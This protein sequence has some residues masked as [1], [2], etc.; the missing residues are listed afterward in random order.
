MNPAIDIIW[1]KRDLR[2]RDHLPLYNVMNNPR[3]VLLLYVFEPAVIADP[4]Y[5]ERHWRFVYQSLMDLQAQLQPFNTQVLIWHTDIFTA[6]EQISQDYQI[7]NLLSHEEIGLDVTYQRDKTLRSYLQQ[8]GI[9]WSEFPYSVVRRGLH[10]RRDW[11]KYWQQEIETPCADANLASIEFVNIANMAILC[12]SSFENKGIQP[13]YN[14]WQDTSPLFQ[15]GGERRAW[16][17]YYSF[18]DGRGKNYAKHIS[19]PALS[20]KSCTRLSPYIAWGNITIKQTYQK[21]ETLEEQDF[22]GWRRALLAMASRLHWHC[23]FIQ[24]FESECDM[25]FRPV[26]LAYA[27][28]PY[29]T[30]E[31]IIQLRL[32]AWLTGQTGIPIVDANMRAV[33]ATGFINFRMRAMLVSVLTHHFNIDWRMGVKHLAAQFLDFEPGIHY[34]QFQMQA[35]VTG[36]NTIRLYNPIKQSQEKDPQGMFIKQWVPELATYPDDM[37]HTPWLITPLEKQLFAIDEAESYPEPI[38]DIETAAK[39]ARD[40]L[41]EFQKSPEVKQD[42]KRILKKHI[43]PGRRNA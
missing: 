22:P 14:E 37:V 8:R 36:T 25:E 6:L 16:H 35:G 11:G 7:I 38:I 20:R 21:L 31:Q 29:E 12:D 3:P 13:L 23:H 15:I 41:W 9:S 2:L 19:S 30:D 32:N 43:V 17:T 33:I 39:V 42:A 28:Y 18:L 4:H 5:S 34:P 40:R 24:K 1:F 27:S 10:H 26:N